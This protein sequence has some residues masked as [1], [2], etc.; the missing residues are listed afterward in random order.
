MNADLILYI[1]AVVLFCLDGFR[2]AASVNFV[3]LGFAAL[4]LS[5]LL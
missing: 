1:L 3:S 4:T 2:V 5:L